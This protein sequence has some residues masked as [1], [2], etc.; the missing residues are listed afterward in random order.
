MRKVV[1]AALVVAVVLL[2]GCQ[3]RGTDPEFPLYVVCV[4]APR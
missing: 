2:S 3:G 4:E 1:V